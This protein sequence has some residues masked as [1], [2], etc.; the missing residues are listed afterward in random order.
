MILSD[1]PGMKLN[2]D[3]FLD[4]YTGVLIVPM[5]E[6]QTVNHVW[7]TGVCL[8]CWLSHYPFWCLHTGPPP[9][10]EKNKT[11]YSNQHFNCMY[12]LGN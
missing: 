1:H 10:G 6:G 7:T 3:H 8:T 9:L 12:H 5:Q 4:K 2:N 11:T